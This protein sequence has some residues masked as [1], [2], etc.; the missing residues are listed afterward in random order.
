MAT[1]AIWAP[2][3]RCAS[4][5]TLI[6]GRS[7]VLVGELGFEAV[8]LPT[9]NSCEDAWAV[10]STL[11]PLTQRLKF[12]VAVR[13]GVMSP[14]LSARMTATFDRLSRGRL[15]INVVTGGDPEE[16]KAEGVF[17]SHDERY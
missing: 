10:A 12:L 16:A 6:S 17:L 2:R 15:L 5:I 9:G 1:A 11:V 13:P 8:L 3:V 7:R 14:T 4:P